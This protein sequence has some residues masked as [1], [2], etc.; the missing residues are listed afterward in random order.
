MAEKKPRKEDL[1]LQRLDRMEAQLTTLVKAQQSLAELKRDVSPLLN[2]AFR[3]I[4]DELGVVESGFQLEDLF[5]LVKRGLRS[6]RNIT[7]ALEQLENIIDLWNAME[8][9]LKSTVPN[10]INYMD[11]GLCP[12]N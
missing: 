10:F 11:P 8:P 9:L 1:L 2:S 4:I 3:I 6:I 5:D 7:Y 12:R